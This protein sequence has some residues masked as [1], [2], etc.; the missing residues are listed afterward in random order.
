MPPGVR[1]TGGNLIPDTLLLI[2]LTQ[3][4]LRESMV[5]WIPRF[6][7]RGDHGPLTDHDFQNALKQNLRGVR[8]KS[9]TRGGEVGSAPKRFTAPTLGNVA[10]GTRCQTRSPL[11]LASALSLPRPRPTN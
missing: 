1:N 10:T 6:A 3:S 9:T 7:E 8:P 11:L 5:V 4:S 2:S